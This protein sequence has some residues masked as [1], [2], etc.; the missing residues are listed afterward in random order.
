[1]IL[2]KR[3][4]VTAS[5]FLALGAAVFVNWYTTKGGADVAPASEQ[6]S[7]TQAVENLGDAQYVYSDVS[8]KADVFATARLGRQKSHDEALEALQ[9]AL[10]DASQSEAAQTQ[11]AKALAELTRRITLEADIETLIQAKTGCQSLVILDEDSAQIILEK[12]PKESTVMLQIS[13]VA[14]SKSGLSAEK[15]TI[16]EA[17]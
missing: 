6:L 11:N 4:L 17:A 1:M 2:K 12:T 8:G 7:A 13:E 9:D 15:I 3:Q 10:S 16:I 5:L 14:S